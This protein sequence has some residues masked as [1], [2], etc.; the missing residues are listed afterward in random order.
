MEPRAKRCMFVGYHD[1]VRGYKLWYPGGNNSNSCISRDVT[2]REE[3]I[4]M[5][6][7]GVGSSNSKTSKRP[8]TQKSWILWMLLNKILRAMNKRSPRSRR[9]S[10]N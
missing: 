5:V 3:Q 1:G 2:F 10:S 8:Q 7:G 9:T 4:Y 6:A